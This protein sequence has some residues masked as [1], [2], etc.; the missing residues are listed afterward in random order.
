M[1]LRTINK[2]FQKKELERVE[3]ENKKRIFSSRALLGE[4]LE[5]QKNVIIEIKNGEI[6]HI[7][8][9]VK[10]KEIEEIKAK[11]RY[12]NCI[13]I[14]GFIN[15]H[16]HI[17]D[18]FAKEL[19]FDLEIDKIVQAPKGLKHYLLNTMD[20]EI[21]IEGMKNTFLEMIY[22]GI[23][24]FV[25]FR[26]N[27]MKGIK[28]LQ[29]AESRFKNSYPKIELGKV[30]LGR[31]K[32]EI[33]E[34]DDILEQCDG[35]GFGSTNKYS[36]EQLKL[37]KEKCQKHNKIISVHVSETKKEHL[38]AEQEFGSS[39]VYRAIL[40]LNANPIVHAI[41]IDKRDFTLIKTK[42]ISIVVCPRANSYLGVGFPPIQEFINEN[43]PVCIGTDNVMLN[44]LNIFR[45]FEYIIKYLRS[46]FGPEII[47]P[48]EVMKMA[49]VYPAKIYGLANKGS[50][51]LEKRAD[52]IVINLE[53]PHL[54]PVHKIYETL[55]LRAGPRDIK[56]VYLGGI[57]FAEI[58]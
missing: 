58:Q 1:K 21:I 48:V 6:V 10:E 49:S 35:A 54:Q 12:N 24:T 31:P 53:S 26:E 34:L 29:E 16:T 55:T 23:T 20:K 11:N 36:D 37:I 19:G 38:R 18:S 2:F 50:I 32:A 27:G 43:I 25:D 47:E 9:N 22:S 4:D 39:D 57:K 45:E 44:S 30:I 5:L 42:D 46:V 33:D 17:G 3:L 13:I 40:L 28:L 51:D 52:L 41:H 7:S 15:G 56:A 14:P 8:R